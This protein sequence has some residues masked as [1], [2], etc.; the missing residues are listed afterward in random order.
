MMCFATLSPTSS[1]QRQAWL[2]LQV[3]GHQQGGAAMMLMC[4][5]QVK[6]FINVE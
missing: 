3:P 1:L 2:H 6:R 4:D 5:D